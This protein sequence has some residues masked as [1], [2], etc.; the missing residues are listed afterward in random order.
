M[1]LDGL[2]PWEGHHKDWPR[3]QPQ[4]DEKKEGAGVGE[5]MWTEVR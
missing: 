3:V 2:C 5:K 4:E 1:K